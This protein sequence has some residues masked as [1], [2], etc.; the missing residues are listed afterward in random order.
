MSALYNYERSNSCPLDS[1]NLNI[2]T[3]DCQLVSTIFSVWFCQVSY[4]N[5]P[6]NR[7]IVVIFYPLALY[8]I[9]LFIYLF[10]GFIFP[11]VAQIHAV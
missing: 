11:F 9:Y 8:V 4:G 6:R 10:E 5:I 2:L 7:T 3:D 1:Q